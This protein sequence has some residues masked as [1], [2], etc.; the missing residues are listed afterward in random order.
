MPFEKAIPYPK[1]RQEKMS[2]TAKP[3]PDTETCSGRL[4]LQG[5]R[6]S[7]ET[8]RKDGLPHHVA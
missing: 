4:C 7:D 6:L 5:N 3:K 1:F 8:G 2:R